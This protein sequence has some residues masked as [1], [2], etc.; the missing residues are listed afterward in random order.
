MNS[1]DKLRRRIS[2][3]AGEA[4]DRQQYVSPIDALVGAGLL[5]PTH[6]ADWRAGRVPYLERVIQ[7]NLNKI[8][9]A[10]KFFH[11]WAKKSGLKPGET[12]YARRARNRCIPLRFSMSG[13][14]DIEKSYSTH[15]ISPKLSELK[16][17]KLQEKLGAPPENIVFS[18]LRES[19]CNECGAELTRGD[20]LYTEVDDA[21]CLGCAGFGDLEYLPAGDTA[22]TRRSKKYSSRTAVI[23]RFSRSRKRYERQGLLVEK[24][25]LARAEEEC[26]SDA[27][28]RAALRAQAARR[29]QKDDEKLVAAMTR[30]I[31]EW[32]PACPTGEARAIAVHTAARGSGRVG[33]TA[34][35]RALR[36]EA[37]TSAVIAAIRHRH[38]SYDKLL[39]SGVDRGSARSE[40]RADVEQVMRR[41]RGS[42][43][44]ISNPD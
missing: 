4:V 7:G 9:K 22:L 39:A 40:V 1:D 29:R 24:E 30:R 2:K 8:S 44:G 17:K 27:D 37:V 13:A 43:P 12:V 5:Q 31:I 38:T 35:G 21:F 25:A 18:I 10:M 20:F 42:E 34:D 6:L 23:V 28:E 16:Q 11:E 32:F 26:T 36:E 3:A 15:Y 33:R 19:A 14:P 41:W